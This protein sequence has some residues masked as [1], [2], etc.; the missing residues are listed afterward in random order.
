MAYESVLDIERL[1]DMYKNIIDLDTVNVHGDHRL[2]TIE[3]INYL[4]T[5]ITARVRR[6]I[7][8]SEIVIIRH[9]NNDI[10]Q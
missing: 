4:S 7:S 9:V 3:F 6:T 10:I 8:N 5:I 1:F 2:C